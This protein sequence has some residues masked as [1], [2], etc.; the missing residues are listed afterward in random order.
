MLYKCST[1]PCV[2]TTPLE[3]SA[4][5]F[6]GRRTSLHSYGTAS[7]CLFPRTSPDVRV[8]YR[9]LDTRRHLPQQFWGGDNLGKGLMCAAVRT[10]AATETAV[11]WPTYCREGGHGDCVV[12]RGRSRPSRRDPSPR[13]VW[14][15]H[16]GVCSV[17][18]GAGRHRE[19]SPGTAK[20]RYVTLRGG[21]E[22][23]RNGTC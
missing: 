6:R 13:V 4:R 8:I 9:Q 22:G 21:C 15:V 20:Q 5:T 17:A 23:N 11:H 19:N 7:P 16:L 12:P 10:P 3:S 1:T 14:G 2:R 18:S